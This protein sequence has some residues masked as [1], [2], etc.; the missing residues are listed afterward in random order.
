MQERPL[1][2]TCLDAAASALAVY[3]TAGNLLSRRLAELSDDRRETEE[4]WPDLAGDPLYWRCLTLGEPLFAGLAQTAVACLLLSRRLTARGVLLLNVSRAYLDPDSLPV[5][6]ELVAVKNVVGNAVAE[7]LQPAMDAHDRGEFGAALRIID[8]V[9]A[10]WPD[11]AWP[12]YERAFTA[13]AADPAI[14]IGAHPSIDAALLRD[15]F[16][17]KAVGA[18]HS[19]DGTYSEMNREA[20]P[21]LGGSNAP[22][23]LARFGVVAPRLDP[24]SAA[25]TALLAVYRDGDGQRG[26]L[27]AALVRLGVAP[28]PAAAAEL[29]LP[30]ATLPR[31]ADAPTLASDDPDGSG[32]AAASDAEIGATLRWAQYLSAAART[33]DAGAAAESVLPLLTEQTSAATWAR[34]LTLAGTADAWLGD[35]PRAIGRLSS[36]VRAHDA[37]PAA[38]LEERVL[39]RYRL[40]DVLSATGRHVAARRELMVARELLGFSGAADFFELL[41][42][43]GL[44][45]VRTEAWLGNYATVLAEIP[46]IGESIND[47]DGLDEPVRRLLIAETNATAGLLFT[48]VGGPDSAVEMLR[49]ALTME[50]SV[51]GEQHSANHHTEALLGSALALDGQHGAAV[52]L[53]RSS[54]AK[55]EKRFG[56]TSHQAAGARQRLADAYRLAGDHATAVGHYLGCIESLRLLPGPAQPAMIDGLAGLGAS[57]AALGDYAAAAAA[58]AEAA[59]ADYAALAADA[60]ASIDDLAE[61]RA[62]RSWVI[63]LIAAIG[64]RAD[65]T[66]TEVETAAAALINAT[67]VATGITASRRA[68]GGAAGTAS[69]LAVLT[70]RYAALAVRGPQGR[71]LDDF[72]TELLSITNRLAKASGWADGATTPE[73]AAADDQLPYLSTSQVSGQLAEGTVFLA[74]SAAIPWQL[75]GQLV[76]G[77]DARYVATVITGTGQVTLRALAPVAEIAA[78]AGQFREEMDLFARLPPIPA[79]QESSRVRLADIG[80][81]VYGHI[82]CPLGGLLEPFAHVVLFLDGPLGQVPFACLV[83]DQGR[84]A[85]ERWLF[86]YLSG[87]HDLHPMPPAGPGTGVLAIAD[88]D[89]GT[90]PPPSANPPPG[91]ASL[92]E[93]LPAGW[94]PLHGTSRELTL[95]TEAIGADRLRSLAGPAAGKLSLLQSRGP[96]VLHLATHAY[97]VPETDILAIP[98]DDQKA[99]LRGLSLPASAMLRTGLVLAGANE[100]RELPPQSP[101]DGILTSLEL[102]TVTDLAGTRLVVLSACQTGVG[103]LVVGDSVQG[104]RRACHMAGAQAVI[105]SLWSLT[106]D[107]TARLIGVLYRELAAGASP[108]YALHRATRCLLD[109]ARAAGAP[110]PHPFWWAGF[111]LTGGLEAVLRRG[112]L[113]GG[114]A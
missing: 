43:V 102:A 56:E 33:A 110:P 38:S 98:E 21:V 96:S 44:L 105:A 41:T 25:H 24:W 51:R 26:T 52:E 112:I 57:R 9:I 29:L 45:L 69:D 104:L 89:F 15:P 111:T 86:S 27:E 8:G 74:V 76:P 67:S 11:E 114:R 92:S 20:G 31:G 4:W 91:I 107:D 64:L 109:E 62:Q 13:C 90:A 88:P 85:V 97:Y 35:F 42:R 80:G 84:F 1:A 3:S 61:L 59:R 37:D 94:L 14:E 30:L 66:A 68:V 78:L 103:D 17:A 71:D 58:L 39:A 32:T 36:A 75:G 7:A 12:R 19:G 60:H 77:A 63:D 40:A 72:A 2:R 5:L 87:I 81:Q 10:R 79:I 16:Y 108:A 93:S 65:A 113:A 22:G 82:L 18:K 34:A 55:S 54:L 101:D 99:D 95:I 47:S 23:A 48:R 28:N 83:D 49:E 46:R 6:D 73:G 106:D 53:L 50:R 100:R 70:S